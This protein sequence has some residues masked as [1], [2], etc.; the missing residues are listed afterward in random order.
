MSDSGNIVFVAGVGILLLTLLVLVWRQ[1]RALARLEEKVGDGSVNLLAEWLRTMDSNLRQ[2]TEAVNRTL[3]RT[4]QAISQ[5]LDAAA[6]LISSVGKEVGQVRQIG[7]QLSS[8]QEMLR[9]P[10][11]RGNLGEEI[12]RDLI[13]QV[14]PRDV[15][16][17]QYR[18]R[19]G[20]VVDA[21]VRTESGLIPIDS[22]FPLE[23][24]QRY[25]RAEDERE[26]EAAW[27]EFRRS[28]KQHVDAVASKYIM[29]GEGT[30]PFALLYVPSEAVYHEIV[31]RGTE[32]IRYAREKAVFVVSPNGFYYFLQVLLLGLQSQ[33]VEEAA[34]QILETLAAIRRENEQLGDA[35]RTLEGHLNNARGALDRV[36]SRQENFARLLEAARHVPTSSGTTKSTPEHI[37]RRAASS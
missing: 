15:Y 6:Q 35:L 7:Q 12:L 16:D 4:N 5:R 31:S 1:R 3:Q 34:Q 25:G 28:F 13:A 36:R 10:K 2:Q 20:L 22:K 30:A 18:F 19:N 21:V 29:P 9:A 27:R 11:F 37:I 14:L 33:R 32:L 24:F 26:K 8:F 17:F 23:A